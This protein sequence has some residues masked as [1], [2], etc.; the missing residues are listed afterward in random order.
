MEWSFHPQHSCQH[1][2]D[3][4]DSFRSDIKLPTSTLLTQESRSTESIILETRSLNTWEE[5]W[6]KHTR[7][8]DHPLPYQKRVAHSR[9]L[10]VLLP[11]REVKPKSSNFLCLPHAHL[12]NCT[13]NYRCTSHTSITGHGPPSSWTQKSSDPYAYGSLLVYQKAKT[14]IDVWSQREWSRTRDARQGFHNGHEMLRS[15][16]RK[17]FKGVRRS[18]RAWSNRG[19]RR[20]QRR[21]WDSSRVKTDQSQIRPTDTTNENLIPNRWL[22]QHDDF[23][24]PK[25]KQNVVFSPG[26]RSYTKLTTQSRAAP[27]LFSPIISS[28]TLFHYRLSFHKWLTDRRPLK[29]PVVK[30][31]KEDLGFFVGVCQ[32][33]LCR[34]FG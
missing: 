15:G 32:S 24:G 12:T 21:I 1:P 18:P 26:H 13:R 31:S 4:S 34:E 3:G 10:S 8:S 20:S 17:W 27:Y 22:N 14:K 7:G 5:C 25:E 11:H 6:L 16:P 33:S 9:N 19:G 30:L 28:T 23:S 2:S 29:E